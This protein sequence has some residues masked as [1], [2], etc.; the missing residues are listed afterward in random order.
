MGEHDGP[1]IRR[2]GARDVADVAGIYLAAF[3]DSL[4]DLG[5]EGIRPVA[6]RD[7]MAVCLDAEPEGFLVADVD[8]RPAGYVICASDAGR[9]RRAGLGHLPAILWRWVRGRYAIGLRAALR[10]AREKL[11]SWR[12]P[13]L[14]GADCPARFVSLAVHPRGQGHGLGRALFEAALDYLR[15][16]GHTRI[17]LEVRPHNAAARR[18]Y[19]TNGFRSVGQVHD[20]RGPWEVMMLEL[21]S[22]NG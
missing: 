8:G 12:H 18:I 15:A 2:A 7:I 14:P 19:E 16:K 6:V 9:I 22:S 13:D 21:G 3:P 17:R 4:R 1:M 20:T 5:L 10:L 11:M